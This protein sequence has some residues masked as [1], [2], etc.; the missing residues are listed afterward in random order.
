MTPLLNMDI[1]KEKKRKEFTMLETKNLIKKF[2]GKTALN[3]ISFQIE[4]GKTYL[5]LGPNGSGKTTWMKTAASLTKPTSGSVLW[6]SIPVGTE[7]RKEISY[8]PTESFFYPWMNVTD[9]GNYYADFF[10]DFE[11][12][13]F[14]DMIREMDLPADAKVKTLSSGMNAKL[15]LAAAVSRKAKVYLLD[16]PLNGIDLVARDAVMKAVISV[17]NPETAVVISSHLVE[18]V[19]SFVSTAIFLRDGKLLEIADIEDLRIRTG[20]SLAD[21]YRELMQ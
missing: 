18:E 10:A 4:P 2:G 13:Q 9:V 21:R 1:K 12:E 20:K 17:M 5:L 15:R 6:N 7:S 14:N 16:E 3:D 11:K 19:E 8:M